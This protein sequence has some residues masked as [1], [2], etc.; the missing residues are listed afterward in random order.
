ML[1]ESYNLSTRSGSEPTSRLPLWW[2][3]QIRTSVPHTI[4]N[5][6]FTVQYKTVACTS[7]GPGIERAFMLKYH[8]ANLTWLLACTRIK[9]SPRAAAFRVFCE[10]YVNKN[11]RQ[12]QLSFI[13]LCLPCLGKKSSCRMHVVIVCSLPLT[14][15]MERHFVCSLLPS[16]LPPPSST[17][18][19]Y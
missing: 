12:R 6:T 17:L 2:C 11:M 10:A 9:N 7:L 3:H 16:S 13:L 19:S 15:A 8:Y 4:A 1:G 18:R 5:V 14:A